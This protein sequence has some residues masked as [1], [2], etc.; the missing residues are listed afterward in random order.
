[1]IMNAKSII[2]I[3]KA[4]KNITD[5]ITT[6]IVERVEESVDS[7][8]AR[9]RHNQIRKEWFERFKSIPAT[10][11][12]TTYRGENLDKVEFETDTAVLVAGKD[13]GDIHVATPYV[14][15]QGTK[16]Y[17][18]RDIYRIDEYSISREEVT[19]LYRGSV[20]NCWLRW[21]ISTKNNLG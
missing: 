9:A 15:E 3:T 12:V 16:M 2:E 14:N 4:L 10:Y 8:E 7:Y 5:I 13:G 11:R 18:V 21:Y 19:L 1:M 17:L 6:E 20:E